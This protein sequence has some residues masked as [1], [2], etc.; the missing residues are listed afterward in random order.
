MIVLKRDFLHWQGAEIW[1]LGRVI[2]C[3]NCWW[4]FRRIPYLLVVKWNGFW[5]SIIL[6]PFDETP[7]GCFNENVLPWRC[8]KIWSHN[9]A[10]SVYFSSGC[11]QLKISIIECA[12]PQ[13]QAI[14]FTEENIWWCCGDESQK[15]L[16]DLHFFP[17]K[18]LSKTFLHSVRQGVNN[19]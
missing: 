15:N 12:H 3:M 13:L 1:D 14:Q 2:W 8:N 18:A 11:S 17:G 7:D 19:R 9:W 5:E 6:C 10:V 4:C 16:K